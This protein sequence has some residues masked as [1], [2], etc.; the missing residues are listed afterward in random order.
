MSL[1]KV[2]T[3]LAN[4]NKNSSDSFDESTDP[5]ISIGLASEIIANIIGQV[6]PEKTIHF[7][8]FGSFSMH[9]LLG[10]LLSVTGPAS[11]YIATWAMTE[12]PCRAIHALKESGSIKELHLLFDYKI[13]ERS[14]QAI[15]LAEGISSSHKYSKC[16]AKTT[17]L[18]NDTWGITVI[19]SANYTR[20]PRIERG[21]ICCNRSVALFDRDWILAEIN[22]T[23]S[24]LPADEIDN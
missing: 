16:H 10:H 4:Q 19:S 23:N 2:N 8:S 11:L 20:N 1:F 9:E 14:P 22:G 24:N 17:V 21:V 12:N 3:L 5:L 7:T 18:V 13:R 6:E 15:Q